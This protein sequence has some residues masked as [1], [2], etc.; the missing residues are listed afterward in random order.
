[1]TTEL[2]IALL[3]ATVCAIALALWTLND[4]YQDTATAAFG[5]FLLIAILLLAFKM[6]DVYVWFMSSMFFMI[7]TLF[8]RAILWYA[9]PILESFMNERRIA[10]RR[11]AE[12]NAQ[13]RE[14]KR[15]KEARREYVEV[16][17]PRYFVENSLPLLCD[18]AL[19][20]LLVVASAKN[21]EVFVSGDVFDMVVESCLTLE[22]KTEPQQRITMYV[23]NYIRASIAVKKGAYSE[24]V[25]NQYL[26]LY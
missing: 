5:L 12:Q 7:Y 14:A 15:L 4:R 26:K 17:A 13:K 19:E 18:E 8:W 23:L 25:D 6:F 1:M 21:G 2:M 22:E 11:K 9:R 3:V 10:Q 16:I 20:D 24:I